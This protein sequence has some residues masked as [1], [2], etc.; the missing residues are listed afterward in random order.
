M[1]T[2]AP[3]S[4]PGVAVQS[5]AGPTA[6]GAVRSTAPPR[7]AGFTLLELLI[8]VAIIALASAVVALAVPDPAASR[9]DREAQRLVQL[10]EAGRAQA[11]SLGLAVAWVPQPGPTGADGRTGDFHFAGL[12][13]GHDLPNRWLE[14]AAGDPAQVIAVELPPGQR[15]V[16]LG[17]EPMI[18]ARRIRLR[19][20]SQQRVLATDGLAPF[21]LQ[22]E[23]DAPLR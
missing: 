23:A 9:L 12:P 22:V 2:S 6:C 16:P 15:A 11:R 18:E 3:G 10:L 8:V 1:P 5:A 14:D 17:P 20:G 4:E 7:S 21:A 19:L 13:A